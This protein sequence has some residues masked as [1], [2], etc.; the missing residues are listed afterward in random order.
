MVQE[1]KKSHTCYHHYLAQTV[2]LYLRCD[3]VS[4]CS[5][6]PA[7]SKKEVPLWKR[8]P[9][10]GNSMNFNSST[11]IFWSEGSKSDVKITGRVII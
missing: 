6:I 10:M 2:R 11:S 8:H 9:M 7:S 5:M 3:T 1:E 4:T